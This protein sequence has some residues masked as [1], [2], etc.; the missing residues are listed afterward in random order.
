MKAEIDEL[1][2]AAIVHQAHRLVGT[3]PNRMRTYSVEMDMIENLER[4]SY[5]STRIARCVVATSPSPPAPDPEA[6]RRASIGND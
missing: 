1:V 2:N 5:V 3:D 4:I 6:T